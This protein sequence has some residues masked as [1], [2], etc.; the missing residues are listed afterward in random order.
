[1]RLTQPAEHLYRRDRCYRQPGVHRRWASWRAAPARN[2]TSDRSRNKTSLG[3]LSAKHD[4]SMGR[5]FRQLSQQ[6]PSDRDQRYSEY[7]FQPPDPTPSALARDGAIQ[8][9]DVMLAHASG[10]PSV[11]LAALSPSL[12]FHQDGDIL[13]LDRAVRTT[14]IALSRSEPRRR[15]S[16]ILSPVRTGALPALRQPG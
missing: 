5:R 13:A 11:G 3:K 12:A 4:I 9:W 15:S 8:F 2:A 14:L 16:A 6:I 10:L 1:M 7:G